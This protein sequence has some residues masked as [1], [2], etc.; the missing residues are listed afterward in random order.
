MFESTQIYRKV[1]VVAV[2]MLPATGSITDQGLSCHGLKLNRLTPRS[3]F[4]WAANSQWLNAIGV[5]RQICTWETKAFNCW[6]WLKDD[7]RPCYLYIEECLTLPLA[8]KNAEVLNPSICEYDLLWRSALSRGIQFKMRSYWI[9]VNP[10]C[11]HW[12]PYKERFSDTHKGKISMWR[13]RQKLEWCSYK[14]KNAKVCQQRAEAGKGQGGIFL[15][16]LQGHHDTANTFIQTS[17]FQNCQVI[18]FC[19]FTPSL[20]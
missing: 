16:S 19:L 14:P 20:W 10:K 12:C 6:L 13:Q 4:P 17:S 3:A 2:R 5:L 7:P 1:H 11:S 8:T 18:N 15:Y 9:T